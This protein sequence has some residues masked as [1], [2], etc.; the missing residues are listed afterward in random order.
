MLAF[1][2]DGD[3]DQLAANFHLERL[4]LDS[5]NPL[6]VPPIPPMMESNE[7][8][9]ARCQMAFKGLSVAGPRG[10]YIHHALSADGQV[11]DVSGQKINRQKINPSPLRAV[12]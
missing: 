8:L 4:E 6:A 11:S 7:D 12:Y 5:G 9:R 1:S 10:A 3:L 2:N